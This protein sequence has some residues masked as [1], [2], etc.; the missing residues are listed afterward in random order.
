MSNSGAGGRV[1]QTFS[2]D[3]ILDSIGV[4]AVNSTGA[5][6]FL[7]CSSLVTTLTTGLSEDNG[8]F[9]TRLFANVAETGAFEP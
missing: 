8:G 5:N 1:G 2:L 9:L 4:G 3:S 7:A 6:S